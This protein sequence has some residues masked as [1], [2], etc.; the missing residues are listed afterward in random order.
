MDNRH[1]RRCTK[2]H[3]SNLSPF[4]R[5]LSQMYQR[6]NHTRRGI[7]T[8]QLQ[9]NWIQNLHATLLS[10][11]MSTLPRH[12]T[13]MLRRCLRLRLFASAQHLV[14]GR[15][16]ETRKISAALPVYTTHKDQPRRP[17]AST[18]QLDPTHRP[19]GPMW[20]LNAKLQSRPT[21]RHTMRCPSLVRSIES[22][23]RQSWHRR[24]HLLAVS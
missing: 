17:N 20:S 2:S 19:K 5:H 10:R 7:Q 1:S 6:H 14:T 13:I 9:F 12:D 16:K 8:G 23:A 4:H 11:S 22:P 15:L 3:T 18:H 21:V 24:H